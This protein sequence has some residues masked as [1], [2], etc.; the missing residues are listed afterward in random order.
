MPKWRK[1]T[2]HSAAAMSKREP[3][4]VR[5]TNRKGAPKRSL[6]CRTPAGISKLLVRAFAH[7]GFLGRAEGESVLLAGEAYFG[8]D[9]FAAGMV[10][11]RRVVVGRFIEV[12]EFCRSFRD[13]L[14]ALHDPYF[15]IRSDAV[16][17]QLILTGGELLAVDFECLMHPQ[18]T[19]VT[20]ESTRREQHGQ[21][22]HNS[23]CQMIQC[24]IV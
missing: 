18:R 5:L 6:V 13:F 21:P 23:L 16:P 3:A 2:P 10:Y 17:P 7:F 20:C 24:Q 9:C 15:D 14:L 11:E 8:N 4:L 1:L 19:F 22:E 12:D